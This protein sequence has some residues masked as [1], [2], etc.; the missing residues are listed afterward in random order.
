MTASSA[1]VKR[2]AKHAAGGAKRRARR[3]NRE[4]MEGS[5]NPWLARAARLGYVIR[6]GLYGVMG[7]LALSLSL[8]APAS[9][10]DQR[11]EVL[12][13]EGVPFAAVVL[14]MLVVGLA[15]YSL[16]GF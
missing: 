12:L 7:M 9:T 5:R 1:R 10:P 4:L 8:G 13:L 16:W 11:G 2:Q 14:A 15:G 6:G 3:V